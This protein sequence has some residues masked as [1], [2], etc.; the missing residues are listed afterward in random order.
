MRKIAKLTIFTASLIAL[1][2]TAYFGLSFHQVIAANPS[3]NL[4]S[5]LVIKPL[6]TYSGRDAV[7]VSI[8][9]LSLDGK[10]FLYGEPLLSRSHDL[11]NGTVSIR[12]LTDKVI[13][14]IQLDIVVRDPKTNTLI[15]DSPAVGYVGELTQGSEVV[16][17][18]ASEKIASLFNVMTEK[19]IPLTNAVLRVGHVFFNDG[20]KWSRGYM[21]RQDTVDPRVWAVIGR[22][23]QLPYLRNVV[24]LRSRG[25]SSKSMM[26][27]GC[28]DFAGQTYNICSA[29]QGGECWTMDD[30]VSGSSGMD[31]IVLSQRT[32]GLIG[33]SCSSQV[34][35]NVAVSCG[36]QGDQ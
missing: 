27:E 32:C 24:Q 11:R 26:S 8:A 20:T 34:Y 30:E 7:P 36:G 21:L 5:N 17:H 13:T 9:R 19:N 10:D 28:G 33:E 25:L 23:D 15:A 1:A 35:A 18:F 12:S 14:S 16:A 6:T 4:P 2:V 22:E 29:G 3:L 31:K